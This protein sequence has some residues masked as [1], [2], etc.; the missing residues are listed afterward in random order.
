MTEIET[1]LD[2][3]ECGGYYISIYGYELSKSDLERLVKDYNEYR[4]NKI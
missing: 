4:K 2:W 3:L 1:F